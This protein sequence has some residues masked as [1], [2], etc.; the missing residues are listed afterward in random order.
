LP[1]NRPLSAGD[2]AAAGRSDVRKW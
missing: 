2:A 1:V